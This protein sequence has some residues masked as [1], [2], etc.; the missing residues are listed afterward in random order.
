MYE[1][2]PLK[3]WGKEQNTWVDMGGE[4]RYRGNKDGWM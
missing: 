4:C 1:N 3:K 2:L